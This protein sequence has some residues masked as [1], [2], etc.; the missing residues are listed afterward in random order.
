MG[1]AINQVQ[2]ELSRRAFLGGL[3]GT[4]ALAALSLTGCA[5]KAT[6]T[7]DT[8]NAGG[9]ADSKVVAG[10]NTV[11]VDDGSTAITLDWLGVAPE[12]ATKDIT[13]TKDTD[14]LIVGAGNGGM[15]AGAYASDQ[16]IDFILCEKGAEVGATRTW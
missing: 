5:P 14:L 8:A 10:I 7:S 3:A 11:A 2:P 6:G 16:K 9:A 4:G 1:K 12:I 15:I 13:E